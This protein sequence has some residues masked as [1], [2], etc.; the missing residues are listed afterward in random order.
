[1]KFEVGTLVR[2][3]NGM[4]GVIVERMPFTREENKIKHAPNPYC[5]RVQWNSIDNVEVGPFWTFPGELVPIENK[6]E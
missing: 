4:M 5:Y 6:K 2:K 3:D 1:M